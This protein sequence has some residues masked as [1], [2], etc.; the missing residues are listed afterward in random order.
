MKTIGAA[1]NAQATIKTTGSSDGAG[2][3]GP[4]T[5]AESA[6]SLA[7]ITTVRE[8]TIAPKEEYRN[9]YLQSHRLAPGSGG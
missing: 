9:G 3:V 7:E 6:R 5:W 1:I 8:G 4:A 2:G